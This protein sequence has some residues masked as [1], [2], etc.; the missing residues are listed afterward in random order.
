M[1]PVKKTI[2]VQLEQSD[3]SET[4][5]ALLSVGNME[6][7]LKNLLDFVGIPSEGK[8]VIL[9]VNKFRI[10]DCDLL[11]CDPTYIVTKKVKTSSIKVY[12]DPIG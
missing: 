1:Q 5:P 4:F 3:D 7:F 11:D 2:K 6:T 8:P 12:L 9:I 10:L